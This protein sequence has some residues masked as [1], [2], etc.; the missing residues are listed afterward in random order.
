MPKQWTE[1]LSDVYEVLAEAAGLDLEVTMLNVNYG[2]NQELMEQCQTLKEYALYVTKVRKNAETMELSEAVEMAVNES[3]EEGILVEFLTR[4][5]RE[6]IQVSILE[7]DEEREMKLIR[8]AEREMGW[9]AGKAEGLALAVGMI[10]KQLQN[11][12]DA[13]EISEFLGIE[14]TLV[15]QVSDLISK[16]PNGDNLE[17]ARMIVGK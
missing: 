9:D 6:A 3:I 7:F 10:R 14:K 13:D 2:K 17:L 12:T 11:K 15:Q 16:D 1:R 5:R 4:Y 8:K